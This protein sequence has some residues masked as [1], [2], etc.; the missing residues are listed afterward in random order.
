MLD[1]EVQATFRARLE[2]LRT[3]SI[4]LAK[5]IAAAAGFAPVELGLE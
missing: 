1:P 4:V 3:T 5:E 2:E